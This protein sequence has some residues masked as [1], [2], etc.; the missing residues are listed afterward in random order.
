MS[1]IDL[2]LPAELLLAE[3]ADAGSFLHG[4]FTT[5]VLA[6]TVGSWQFSAWLDAAGRVRFLFHLMRMTEQR[7]LLLLRGGRAE[8]L[9]GELARFVFRAK[10][11]LEALPAGRL[12]LDAARSLYLVRAQGDAITLGCGEFS[13]TTADV[14]AGA[15]LRDKQIRAGWPWLFDDADTRDRFTAA[16]LDLHRLGA[17]ALGKGCYPGQEIVA[18][19]HY[20]GGNKRR[21]GRITLS[22]SVPRGTVLKA[23][24]GGYEIH[25]LD[26]VDVDRACAA[27]A[28]IPRDIVGSTQQ[29]HDVLC[30]D[31]T[32][33]R[34]DEVWGE[35]PHGPASP[36]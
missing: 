30:T 24:G 3:G 22:R 9:R 2:S 18:R 11:R 35:S 23:S 31:G 27:I 33:A 20:K 12:G 19:L 32:M 28:V 4:Q 16:A 6:M 10:V 29:A 26:V 25:L 36:R 8:D 13:M 34:I 1:D 17:V 15:P 7:W 21:L 14:Q 5:D